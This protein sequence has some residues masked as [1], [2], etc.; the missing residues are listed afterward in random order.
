[1]SH[2]SF[3]LA[4]IQNRSPWFVKIPKG[5]SVKF[6]SRKQAEAYLAD[7][8]NPKASIS[9]G[10]TAWEAQIRLID[11]RGNEI[12]QTKTFTRES[13]A[14]KWATDEEDRILGY[15]KE[16]GSF[17]I[18]LET[19][20]FEDALNRTVKE[21]YKGMASQGQNEDRAVI[22]M[23]QLAQIGLPRS[24]KLKEI[25]PNIIRSYK[26][27]LFEEEQYAV[28][29]VKNYFALIRQTFKHARSEWGF[30][31]NDPAQGI[32]LPKQNNAIERYW[33]SGQ[34]ERER[35]FESIDKHRPWLRPLVELS[36]EMSFRLGELVPRTNGEEFKNDG[37]RWEGINFEKE[38]VRLF[39][40]KNDH[41]KKA[42]ETRGRTVPMTPRMKEIF[43][44]LKGDI[45]TPTGRVFYATN[46][47]IDKAFGHCCDNAEPPI[48]DLTFHSLRK[49]ATVDLSKAVPNAMLLS[50]LTGHKTIQ[51]LSD[52]YYD[53]PIEDLQVML[54]GHNIANPLVKG[55]V[56]LEKQLGAKEAEAFLAFVKSAKLRGKTD[57]L[58]ALKHKLDM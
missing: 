27:F 5:E 37:L 20:T 48:T 42:T 1:M 34:N 3:T 4:N 13:D 38:T 28:S 32:T 16:T 10:D 49:I 52:R 12:N 25:T 19:M 41:T 50:K 53:T 21:H 36:L 31:I 35:L 40:E 24:I 56:V 26:S 47:T 8:E 2:G 43:T 44:E 23:D 51:V 9:Q 11:P 7:L 18:A 6:R 30:D 46:S 29:T 17:N 57:L 58:K 22:I 55:L 14:I 15:K 54:A 45:K 33:H 39:K